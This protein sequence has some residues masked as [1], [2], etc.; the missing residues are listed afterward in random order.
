MSAKLPAREPAAHIRSYVRRL[1]RMT[2]AQRRALAEFWPR[3]GVAGAGPIDFERLFGR[4]AP[5]F[6]EIGFGMGDALLAMASAHPQWD[7]LGVEVY[8][9]GVGRLLAGLAERGL[10]NVRVVHDDIVPVLAE[11]V[12][13]RS[14]RG[15]FLFFPDP[16]PKSRHHKRRLVS[17]DFAE[18]VRERLEPGGRLYL[19]TDSDDYARHMLGVLEANPG[20]VNAAGPGRFASRLAE[21]PLTK[22]ER[23]GEGLGHPVR[24]MVFERVIPAPA[25]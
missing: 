20:F 5:R 16:W 11:R 6:L 23:R 21:R 10:G 19:A 24:D 4:Q 12:P 14:L 3:Y 8:D 9:P 22:F 1:G 15:V 13:A 25:A 17:A 7:Y 18:L 2:A